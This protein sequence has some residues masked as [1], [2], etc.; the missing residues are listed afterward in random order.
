MTAAPDSLSLELAVPST[1]RQDDSVR[2]TLRIKNQRNEP[3]DL[4]LRGRESTLD[5]IVA[6][7]G[8]AVVWHR[9][10]GEIIPAIVHVRTLAAQELL[11]ITASWNLRTKQG[12]P[13]APGEYTARGLLLAEGSPLEAPAVTFRVAER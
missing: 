12:T 3:L 8:G 2:F 13:V 6:Q 9:M 10:E 5:V 1:G 7:P 4:Y 11:E